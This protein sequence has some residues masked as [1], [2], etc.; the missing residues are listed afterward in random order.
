LI[1]YKIF[2]VDSVLISHVESSYL[3]LI[4]LADVRKMQ[5]KPVGC[6]PLGILGDI[7]FLLNVMPLLS[8]YLSCP[9]ATLSGPLLWVS[10]NCW[11]NP[12][13]FG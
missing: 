7:V 9:K 3:F 5:P 12:L 2:A 13:S 11:G 4:Q 6:L 8:C 10:L 1:S